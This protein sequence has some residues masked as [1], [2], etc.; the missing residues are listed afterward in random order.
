MRVED[1]LFTHEVLGLEVGWC[2]GLFCANNVMVGSRNMEWIQDSLNVLIGIFRWYRLVAVWEKS[3]L[4]CWKRWW[5]KDA[6]AVGGGH[7]ESNSDGV[8]PVWTAA[9]NSQWDW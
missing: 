5:T 8:S 4:G 3:G 7:T 2:L 1:E 9:W 6:W